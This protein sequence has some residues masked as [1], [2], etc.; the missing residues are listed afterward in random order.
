MPA[1]RNCWLLPFQLYL[2]NRGDIGA[3]DEVTGG[4][5]LHFAAASDSVAALD[6]LL[7][8]GLELEARDKNGETPLHWAAAHGT[9]EMI[10]SLLDRGAN[11]NAWNRRGQ[12]PLLVCFKRNCNQ[13]GVRILLHLGADVQVADIYG[14]TA[15]HVAAT[16]YHQNSLEEITTVEDIIDNGG[17]VNAANASG[18]TPLHEALRSSQY[19]VGETT[20]VLLRAGANVHCQDTYGN[21]PLH[22]ALTPDAVELLIEKGS[23]VRV[24]NIQGRTCLHSFSCS[25]LDVD[26]IFNKLIL[27]GVDVNALMS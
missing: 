25:A 2:D 23:D 26:Q 11:V 8:Q 13:E 17:D 24:T 7:N 6:H 14:N 10:L 22:F 18:Y 19:G 15:L 4:T 1:R 12:T 20:R 16:C 27:K 21:T 5:T 9:S 3:V